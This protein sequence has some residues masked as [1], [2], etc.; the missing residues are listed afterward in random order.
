MYIPKF[1]RLEDQNEALDFIKTFSFGTIV[2]SKDNVPTATHLPFLIEL[3]NEKI[4]LTSHFAKANG[5]WKDVKENQVL[6]IFSEPHAYVSPRNYQKE[7]NVP[8]WNYIAVHAYGKGRLITDTNKVKE[9]LENTILNYEASYKT[10]WDA[11]PK[12]YKER[13]SKGIV[14]FEIEV[15]DLQAKKKLSQNKTAI[16]QKNI[17]HSLSNSLNSN[18]QLI[19]HYME[20]E[21]E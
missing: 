17:I 8:T 20:K 10:Q 2:T 16:E 7:L 5:Q 1:N 13:M 19:A 11:L 14:A 15:E 6:T 4:L 3:K 9:V 18:E 21:L 12:D